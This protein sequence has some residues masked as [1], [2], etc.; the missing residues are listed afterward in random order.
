MESSSIAATSSPDLLDSLT[1]FYR[2]NLI[3]TPGILS[4]LRATICGGLSCANDACRRMVT[5][6]RNHFAH[7]QSGTSVRS[8]RNITGTVQHQRTPFTL[9]T[10]V[11]D[12]SKLFKKISVLVNE[13]SVLI[14]VFP[15]F[16]LFLFTQPV[17]PT[18]KTQNA[19][20]KEN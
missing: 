2:M 13:R 3:D 9:Q 5:T 15:P 12:R 17:H 1:P 11:V 7:R 20:K 16:S 6:V 14:F 19:A 4:I 8:V 10:S 18:V